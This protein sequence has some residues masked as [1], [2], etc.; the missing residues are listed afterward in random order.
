M[1]KTIPQHYRIHLEPDLTSFTFKGRTEVMI[2]AREPVTSITLNAV[3]LDI[4]ECQI[5]LDGSYEDAAFSELDEETQSFTIQLPQE[6]QG[7]FEVLIEYTGSINN[8]MLG[9]YRSKYSDKEGQEKYIAVTQFEEVSARKAFPCFDQPALKATFDI[10]YVIDSHLTGISNM[11]VE[12]ER[13]LPDGKKRVKFERTPIMSTYL[14]FFGVGEF[15]I[16]EDRGDVLL[17]A[18]T[19]PGK[20]ELAEEGLKFARECVTFLEDHFGTK[21]PLPK[22]DLIAVPDFAFGAME[23]WGAMTFRENLLLVYPGI[24][25]RKALQSLLIT[26]AHEIVHMWFGDL[27]SPAEWKYLWLNESFATI[28]GE[29]AVDQQRPEWQTMESFLLETTAGA[30]SRDSLKTN[31]AVELEDEA[32]ITSSTAPIIYDKGGSVL[33]MAVAYLGETVKAALKDYFERHAFQSTESSDLWDAFGRAARDESIANMM[34]TWVKQPGHPLIEVKKENGTLILSQER[35]TYLDGGK[36]EEEWIIPLTVLTIDDQGRKKVIKHILSTR[37]GKLELS[38]DVEAFK[39]NH[40]QT[41]FFR[42]KYES[43]ALEKLG[44]LIN[45]KSIEGLDRYGIQEDLFAL[46]R[47]GDV[48]ILDYLDYINAYYQKEDHHLPLRGII[49]NLSLLNLVIQGP[50]GEK[51]K[52]AGKYLTEQILIRIGYEPKVDELLA[53]SAL[54]SSALW[55]A[56]LFGSQQAVDFSLGQFD[57]VIKTGANIHPDIADPVQRIAAYS[58]SQ[59]LEALIGRFEASDSEQERMILSVVLGCVQRENMDKVVEFSLEEM[60]PRLQY[61]PLYM[62]SANPGLTPYLWE[63]FRKNQAKLE[64]FHPLYFERILIGVISIGGLIQESD[65]KGF[66]S[67]YAPESLKSYQKYLRQTVDMALEMLDVNLKMRKIE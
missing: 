50:T 13:E 52:Q 60:P 30:L 63:M 66:F 51:I 34:I 26:I 56:A 1:E 44:K 65:I 27:V 57:K 39:L 53:I 58:D 7:K 3:D 17:R 25:S 28:Y 43:S 62:M 54:R 37:S 8:T 29:V 21:Y 46:V 45:D 31:F 6:K 35:F 4:Q 33:R 49:K 47:R 10:E 18:I 15:E 61:I 64:K 67:T 59:S 20:V 2:N 16:K 22:L 11:P 40:D 38:D 12:E 9:F 19:T 42:V 24:T 48:S 55:N 23:N 32:R 14:L 5:S 36:Y 41:G